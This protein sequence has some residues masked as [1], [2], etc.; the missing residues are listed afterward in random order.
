[1]RRDKVIPE[2]Q[3]KFKKHWNEQGERPW[4]TFSEEQVRVV[5]EIVAA[6]KEK[7]PTIQ[8]ILGHDMVNLIN[9]LDPGPLYPLGDLRAAILGDSQLGITSYRT[10]KECPIYE[11][12]G[13]QPPK[14]LPHP[15]FGELP[16]NSQVRVREVHDDWTLVKVKQSS[17][18][19]LSNKEG[20]VLSNS[21]EPK[22]DKMITKVPQK[23]Y[24]YIPASEVRL[25]PK[26][27]KTG[28]L[29]EGTHVR[30]QFEAGERWW[31]VAPVLEVR[32]NAEG[33]SEVVIPDE[34]VKKKFK[35][36]WVEQEF[37]EKV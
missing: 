20:W 31:L 6:L 19:H 26:E 4:Q 35:E 2:E 24:Q 30:I 7:Y 16:K 18:G 34:K 17:Q 15:D 25:P 5:Q 23:F 8:E 13:N 27:L 33:K 1:M 11:N 36:G 37:L 32:K 28:A 10:T 29:P 12:F 14:L 22:K 3:V 9:R 21:I